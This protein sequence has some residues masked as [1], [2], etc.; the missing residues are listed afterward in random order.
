MTTKKRKDLSLE[1]ETLEGPIP[2]LHDLYS[3]PPSKNTVSAKYK[4]L[5][6]LQLNIKFLVNTL[7]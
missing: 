5:E 1:T 6:I 4:T 3:V 2:N 7:L